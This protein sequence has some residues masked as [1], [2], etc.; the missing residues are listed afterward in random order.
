MDAISLLK[1]DHREVT[2]LFE[3]FEEED[4]ADK[5]QIA[6]DRCRM[7]TVHAQIEEDIFYPVAR[8]AFSADDEGDDL[9]DEAEVE[10]ASAKDLIAQIEENGDS[11]DLFEAKVKVLG[12]Y[13][14]HHV[15]EEEGEMFPRVKQTELNLDAVGKELEKRKAELIAQ[16]FDGEGAASAGRR[17]KG[18]VEPKGKSHGSAH[19]R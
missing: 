10:H 14:K 13:I 15:K 5:A 1:K 17:P 7:L 2:K 6:S 3:A 16:L 9:L 19:R 18:K 8:E 4:G 12:E 11:D